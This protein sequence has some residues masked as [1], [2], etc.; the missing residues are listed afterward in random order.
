[1]DTG[2]NKD[3]LRQMVKE[4]LQECLEEKKGVLYDVLVEVVEDLALSRAIT[5]GEES[6]L[7]DSEEV[8]QIISR[9]A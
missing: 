1:M 6:E 9:Q 7:A 4:V 3:T 8:R 2:S 5:E